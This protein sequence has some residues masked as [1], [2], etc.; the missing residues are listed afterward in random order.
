MSP[1]DEATW[2]AFPSLLLDLTS[3][4][5]QVVETA[6]CAGLCGRQVDCDRIFDDNHARI[7]AS[8]AYV[9]SRADLLTNASREQDRYE[10]LRALVV[11][12][13]ADTS[14]QM[15][16]NFMIE[17]NQF[18]MYGKVHSYNAA[19]K[20]TKDYLAQK[21]LVDLSDLEVVFVIWPLNTC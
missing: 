1:D 10:I 2:S 18:W 12:G 20:A 8:P 17:D 21:N 4:E 11:Q 7:A 3:E 5:R 13:D 19:R 14:L 15:L 9:L 16:L 6:V